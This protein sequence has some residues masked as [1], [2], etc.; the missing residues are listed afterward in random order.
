MVGG[1]GGGGGGVAKGLFWTVSHMYALIARHGTASAGG[2]ASAGGALLD[3]SRIARVASAQHTDVL[4]MADAIVEALAVPRSSAVNAL[5][6]LQD[7]VLLGDEEHARRLAGRR[8]PAAAA[9]A[10][11]AACSPASRA[12]SRRSSN[13][14]HKTPG[15]THGT[16]TDSH[17]FTVSMMTSAKNDGEPKATTLRARAAG[18]SM[19]PRGAGDAAARRHGV[20][21]EAAAPRA[22]AAP[23]HGVRRRCRRPR[24]DGEA[25]VRGRRDHHAYADAHAVRRCMGVRIAL[26]DHNQLRPFCHVVA[27]A[28]AEHRGCRV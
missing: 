7:F 19:H 15:G 8:R 21:R 9:A 20:S 27:A 11:A 12:A 28:R 4:R 14:R 6:C 26:G 5:L 3:V 17:K 13:R 2:D 16:P 10:A 18:R 22:A 23:R 25:R 24:R 1:G